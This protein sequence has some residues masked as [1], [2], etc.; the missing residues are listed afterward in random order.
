M[1]IIKQNNDKSRGLASQSL[2]PSKGIDYI[3]W[4][5]SFLTT[6]GFTRTSPLR[7]TAKSGYTGFHFSK[8]L[9]IV[10]I[11]DTWCVIHTSY[12]RSD[13]ICYP[14][15]CVQTWPIQVL[16]CVDLPLGILGSAAVASSWTWASAAKFI[17]PTVAY[18]GLNYGNLSVQSVLWYLVYGGCEEI[19]CLQRCYAVKVSPDFKSLGCVFEL[20]MLGPP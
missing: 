2:V 19:S 14:F 9:L 16:A 15:S 11:S 10:W 7:L 12:F 8:M 1:N 13:Y 3:P 5:G 18:T 4:Y 6:V 20:R 17:A